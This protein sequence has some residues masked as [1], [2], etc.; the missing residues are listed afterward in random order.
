VRADTP[1]PFAIFF[2]FFAAFPD[3][4][5]GLKRESFPLKG[6][7]Q[8]LPQFIKNKNCPNTQKNRKTYVSELCNFAQ[9][10]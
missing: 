9:K 10:C 8:Y 4:L 2:P 5:P 1:F 7:N 3:E 6:C